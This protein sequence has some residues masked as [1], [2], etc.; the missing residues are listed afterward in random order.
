MD[1]VQK[2]FQGI[3][4]VNLERLSAKLFGCVVIY[5]HITPLRLAARVAFLIATI[6]FSEASLYGI[7]STSAS[8]LL[9]ATHL[10]LFHA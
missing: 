9:G 8:S 7:L 1:G 10:L 3:D 2:T 5:T 6:L 4:V